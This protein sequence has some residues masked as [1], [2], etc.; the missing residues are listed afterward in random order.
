VDTL[1]GAGAPFG[2]ELTG[3]YRNASATC[4]SL[5]DAHASRSAIVRATFS[6]L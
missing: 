3:R 5:I 1:L 2:G 6:T 4:P